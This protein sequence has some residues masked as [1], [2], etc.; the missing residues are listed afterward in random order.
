M[1]TPVIPLP[2]RWRQTI[3]ER[4]E[5]QHLSERRLRNGRRGF[6]LSWWRRPAVAFQ[7]VRLQAVVRRRWQKEN[8]MIGTKSPGTL[9]S[10]TAPP[11]LGQV[12]Q[13]Q[14]AQGKAGPRPV[15]HPKP[16]RKPLFRT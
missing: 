1:P 8:P 4:G 16:G 13:T 7:T 12:Q 11:T 9:S 6:A 10:H 15:Q 5:P 3:R 14:E 2:V